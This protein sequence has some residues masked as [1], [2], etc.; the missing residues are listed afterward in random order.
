M[1]GAELEAAGWVDPAAEWSLTE[2]IHKESESEQHLYKI[3][4]FTYYLCGDI[5]AAEPC[6]FLQ[7]HIDLPTNFR[8]LKSH[9]N[10]KEQRGGGGGG[11]DA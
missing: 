6:Y 10:E 5:W 11:G 4:V 3:C 7:S 1:M 8:R 2:D 9:I